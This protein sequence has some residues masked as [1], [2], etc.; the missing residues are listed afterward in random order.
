MIIQSLTL[1]HFRQFYGVQ[2]LVFGSEEDEIVT[3]IL[4]ENGRGKTGIYRAMI[5]GLYG[6]QKLEQDSSDASLTLTNT[7]ALQEDFESNRNGVESKVIVEF[8]HEGKAYSIERSLF[9]IMDEK[10]KVIE[11]VQHVIL[12][13]KENSQTIQDEVMV[14]EWMDNILDTRVKDYFFFDGERIERLTRAAVEQRNEI[15]SGIKN[16]LKIDHLLKAKKVL[17]HLQKQTT[18]ELQ[19]HSTG[20]YQKKL[21]EKIEIEENVEEIYQKKELLLQRLSKNESILAEIEKKLNSYKGKLSEI[22]RR[23]ELEK[24]LQKEEQEAEYAFQRLQ[25]FNQTLPYML[26]KNTLYSVKSQVDAYLGEEITDVSISVELI[27]QLLED[28][29]CICG[30]TFKDDSSEYRALKSLQKAAG[31]KLEKAAYF[32]LKANIMK[33]IGFVEDKETQLQ[34]LLEQFEREEQEVEDLRAQ[35]EAVNRK[36]KDTKIEDL[37]QLNERRENVYDERANARHELQELEE[38]LLQLNNQ[39]EQTQLALT[40]LKVKSGVHMQLVEKQNELDKSIKAM[41]ELILGFEADVISELE[42]LSTQNF[43]YLLD[44]SGQMNIKSVQVEKDYSLEVLNVYNH[45]FLANISQ[46]QRQVLSLSF[47]TALAQVAGGTNTLEM[48]LFM[49]TPF[50]RLSGKH[51]NNLLDFIPNVCSQWILLVTDR[52]FGL[53]EREQFISRDQVGKFYRLDSTEPS[54]TKIIE[55]SLQTV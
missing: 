5:F 33:L 2:K 1:Q 44:E 48:P 20:D 12:S 50:G 53:S 34:H 26:A 22:E 6:D 13:D 23:E 27:N 47:I 8:L 35:I 16:L 41:D 29:T 32:E 40:N 3:V 38:Q 11:R 54:V 43:K 14:N 55:E 19:K 46:G 21:Q 25:E 42:M 4:G 52:E 7:K 39:K 10:G 49:D 17:A 9:S 51:Q 45:P 37:D 31:Y 24:Q 18:K 30:N 15:S 36:L 28:L